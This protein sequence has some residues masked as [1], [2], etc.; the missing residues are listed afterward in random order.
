[1]RYDYYPGQTL[2]GPISILDCG[3][4]KE[5]SPEL[6]S[7]RKNKPHKA[8]K[9]TLEE[10]DFQKLCVNWLCRANFG[11]TEGE[12]GTEQPSHQVTGPDLDK[13]RMLNVFEPCTLQIGDR[14][15]Y[16]IKDTDLIMSKSEWRK[17]Q[18]EQLAKKSNQGPPAKPAAKAEEAKGGAGTKDGD[19]EN[20]SDYEDCEE[21]DT[22]SNTSDK[23]IDG[24]K[25]KKK[26]QPGLSTR[27]YKKKKLKMSKAQR[28][29]SAPFL[30]VHKDM[31]VVTETLSTRS[32]VRKN[33]KKRGINKIF[34]TIQFCL[35]PRNIVSRIPQSCGI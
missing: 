12:G 4:W 2:F 29:V 31:K 5:C 22:D 35:Y 32:E 13:V 6:T 20:S 27:V 21:K 11:S 1:M 30:I 25:K 24:T 17:L 14:N 34:T 26:N 7:A 23:N 28:E 10:I 16:V 33:Y 8:Y 19:G 9:M 18:M 3:D 15:F